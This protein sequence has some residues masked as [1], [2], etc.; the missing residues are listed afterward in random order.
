MLMADSNIQSFGTT[1]YPFLEYP[2]ETSDRTNKLMDYSWSPDIVL[3]Q[4]ITDFVPSLSWL[5][6]RD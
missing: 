1:R 2:I 6:R 4:I 3:F 5:C